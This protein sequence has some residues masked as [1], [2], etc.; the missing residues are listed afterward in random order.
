MSFSKGQQGKYRPLINQAWAKYAS[1]NRLSPT[2]RA[3]R[4]FWYRGELKVG[5]GVTSSNNL[6][7]SDGFERAMAHFES[8]CGD[9]IY[10]QLQYFNGDRRRINHAAS[11]A[12]HQV[13]YSEAYICGAATRI[14]KRPIAVLREIDN[15][16]ER[17]KV[18]VAFRIHGRRLAK[19]A[20]ED[21]QET[22][23]N[24]F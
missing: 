13:E 5:C 24:P 6:S 1:A 12:G 16:E 19:K 7:A 4:E 15:Y 8:I 2:D 23:E 20:N 22:S 9:S 21:V 11:S 18:K 3:A 14:L 17:E 10:W